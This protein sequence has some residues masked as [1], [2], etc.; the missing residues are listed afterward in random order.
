MSRG[1]AWQAQWAAVGDITGLGAMQAIELVRCCRT[2]EPAALETKEV[3]RLCWESG[4]ILLS[5]GCYDNVIRLL[6]LLTITDEQFREGLGVLECALQL[7]LQARCVS[8]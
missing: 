6:V 5:A 8:A 7:V 3:V 1:Q 4:L 2:Q